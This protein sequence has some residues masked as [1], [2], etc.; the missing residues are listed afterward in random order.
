MSLGPPSSGMAVLNEGAPILYRDGAG[1][2]RGRSLEMAGT[3][4]EGAG[5]ESV[6]LMCILKGLV[7]CSNAMLIA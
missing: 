6:N 7:M 5:K 3:C 2:E 4:M 1:G